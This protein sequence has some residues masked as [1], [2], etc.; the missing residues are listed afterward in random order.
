MYTSMLVQS[1]ILP[2][3]LLIAGEFKEAQSIIIQVF[4]WWI[5]SADNNDTSILETLFLF[6]SRYRCVLDGK[7]LAE[8]FKMTSIICWAIY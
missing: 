5:F 3:W 7:L 6:A 4:W 2:D 1:F 8:D